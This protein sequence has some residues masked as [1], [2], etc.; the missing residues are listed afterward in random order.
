LYTSGSRISP[1]HPNRLKSTPT[2]M[3][4]VLIILFV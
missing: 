4:I 2:A 3:R 1:I